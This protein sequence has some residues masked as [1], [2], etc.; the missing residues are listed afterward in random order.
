M[1]HEFAHD[2]WL[3]DGPEIIGAVGFAFPTRMA[4]I[5]TDR[6]LLIWSPIAPDDALMAQIAELGEVGFLLAPNTLH[7]TYLA[8]WAAAYPK[9]QIVGAPGV[10]AKCPDL[11]VTELSGASFGGWGPCL[12]HQLIHGNAIVLEAVLFHHA[13]GTVIFTDLLQNMPKGWYK[14]WRAVVARLDKMVGMEPAVPRKFRM[15]FTDRNVA[16]C[17]MSAVLSWP[18]Q[19]VVMAHGTPVEADGG[20]FLRRAFSWLLR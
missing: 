5:R 12:S 16:R 7:V 18:I 8:Q 10:A 20:A 4:V 2:I 15:A 1:L 13:S 9:A 11:P 19:R 17:D 6:G 14:G 3:A